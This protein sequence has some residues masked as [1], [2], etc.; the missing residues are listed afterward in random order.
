MAICA[1]AL[2][3]A[4]AA[5]NC[6]VLC[7]AGAGVAGELMLVV[8]GADQLPKRDLM[9]GCDAVCAVVVVVLLLRTAA[10]LAAVDADGKPVRVTVVLLADSPPNTDVEDTVG[11]WTGLLS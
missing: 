3:A 7:V 11:P 10:P 6:N 5:P 9:A 2:P 4:A 8:D 1:A